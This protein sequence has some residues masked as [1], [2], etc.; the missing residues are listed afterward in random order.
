MHTCVQSTMYIYIME[1]PKP[2]ENFF[3]THNF[4]L[5]SGS[6]FLLTACVNFVV[7]SLQYTTFEAYR[8]TKLIYWL[9]KT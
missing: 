4:T 5:Y 1:K 3:R 9:K 2:Y 8:C 6:H 7:F